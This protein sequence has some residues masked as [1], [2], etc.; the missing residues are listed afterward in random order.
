MSVSEWV[1][2]AVCL[3]V[4]TINI[5]FIYDQRRS[6]NNFGAA[7]FESSQPASLN[8]GR[9]CRELVL[10]KLRTSIDSQIPEVMRTPQH[11]GLY[12][13]VVHIW[14]ANARQGQSDHV[15]ILAARL[16]HRFGCARNRGSRDRHHQLHL[17]IDLQ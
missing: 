2:T 8:G 4:Q 7:N 17:R 13:S 12:N 11:Y 10:R 16:T 14:L 15:D 1:P 5:L 3:E 6:E 9:P